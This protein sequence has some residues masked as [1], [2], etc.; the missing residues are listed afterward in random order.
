MRRDA[1]GAANA[2][3]LAGWHDTAGHMKTTIDIPDPILDEAKKLAAREGTTV[4]ALVELG[5]RRV[6]ADRRRDAG[7]R[8]RKAAFRGNGLRPEL[9]GA[10]WE[11]IRELAY[12]GHGG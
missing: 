7:F 8:L 3:L 2:T 11:R 4:K 1:V 5:L 9:E 6:I 10:S 12:E